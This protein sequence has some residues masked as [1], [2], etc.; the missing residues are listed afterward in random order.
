MFITTVK[1]DSSIGFLAVDDITFETANSE[2]VVEPEWA[3]PAGTTSS[4]TTQTPPSNLTIL[5]MI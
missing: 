4:P 2:C 3:N 5:L 1:G